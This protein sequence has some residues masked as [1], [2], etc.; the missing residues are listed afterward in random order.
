MKMDTL[1]PDLLYF[2]ERGSGSPLLLV[3]GLGMSGDM[4]EPIVEPLSKRHR[5]II[6]D[7][8]GCGRSRNLPPPYSVKRQAADLAAMLDHLGV[9]STDAL[10]YSQGGPVVQELALDCPAKA[11]R[12]ILSNTYAYNMATIKE[13]IEGYAVPLLVRLLGVQLFVK[14]MISRG[15]KQ[16]PKERAAWV[17]SLISRTWGEA[18]PKS[19]T[20]AWREAMAFDSRARLKEIKSPTLVIAGSD[21]NAVPIHHALMLRD[22]IAGSKLVV[23]EGADHTLLWAHSDQLLR[24]VN[25]FLSA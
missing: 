10:G 24:A 8:R 11:C 20:L 23:I 13:R 18:D 16:I 4:F 1:I 12:L 7:L 22:G 3:H 21:D 19:I 25:E 5:L 6:P 15:L 17:A 14:L 2:T 9:A